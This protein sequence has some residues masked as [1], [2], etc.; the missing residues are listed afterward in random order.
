MVFSSFLWCIERNHVLQQLQKRVVRWRSHIF[1]CASPSRSV[2]HIFLPKTKLW[3]VLFF[4]CMCRCHSVDVKYFSL[5]VV[6]SSFLIMFLVCFL[7]LS[8]YLLLAYLS[9][10]LFCVFRPLHRRT[11]AETSMAWTKRRRGFVPFFPFPYYFPFFPV[12]GRGF[13]SVYVNIYL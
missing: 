7:F 9:F 5:H 8:F 2:F 3:V 13:V 4:Y 10:C 6:F 12:K 1:C 11:P